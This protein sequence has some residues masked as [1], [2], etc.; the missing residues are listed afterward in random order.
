MIGNGCVMVIG[1]NE[2]K[3]AAHTSLL[4]EFVRRAGGAEARIVIVPSASDEPVRRAAQY[5]RIF[6][7]LGGEEVH[8]GHSGLGGTPGGLLPIEEATRAFAAGGAQ[9]V[10]L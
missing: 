6:E 10:L 3:R 2:D 7:K 4:A 8:A 1:G 5:R 9:E